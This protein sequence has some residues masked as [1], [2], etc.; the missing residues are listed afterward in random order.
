[1][2]WPLRLR[3][4]NDGT[5][6]GRPV[7]ATV[8]GGVHGFPAVVT[9][10][11]GRDGPVRQVAGL[12]EECRLVT[13]TGSGGSGKTRLAGQVARRRP[14]GSPTGGPAEPSAVQDRR[15]LPKW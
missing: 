11:I 1:M 2:I 10:F 7:A 12:L 13:V 9:S 8:G 6:V 15:R 4:S 3:E 5:D 14:W